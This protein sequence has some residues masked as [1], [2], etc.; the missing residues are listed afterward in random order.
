[1][2]VLWAPVL[3]ALAIRLDGR[4]LDGTFGRGGHARGI[5]DRLGPEGRLL[6]M[7]KDPEAIR[8]AHALA[9]GDARVRVRHASFATLGEW[10]ETADGL[11]GV[12]FDL[13]V[14]SP[15]LDDAAR[16]FSFRH[17]GPLDMRMDP[18]QGMS[19]ADF[20]NT[21]DEAEIAR[22]LWT[23]GEERQAR[24]IARGIVARRAERPFERTGD[25]ADVIAKLLGRG[26]GRTHPATRS[27]QAL[28]I[29]V[30]AEL[31][32]LVAGLEAAER[33]L[34]VGGRLAVI[35]FHSLEDRITK[36]FIHSRAKAPPS[37][38]RAMIEA[39]FTPRLRDISGAVKADEAELAANPRARSAVL[40]VA[41]KLAVAEGSA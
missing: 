7:D 24:R 33:A 34:K 19:A 38:R 36:Q 26:D 31:E 14:S 17:D 6:V 2:P 18:T 10:D 4:Y 32:D 20:V 12:L 30:N 3:A 27:F 8:V 23:H 39:R 28:R 16:G 13:G 1:M 25:L 5:L 9:A 11:D 37:N 21:A 22:V 40:R 41:E 35:S 29:H 15:Q